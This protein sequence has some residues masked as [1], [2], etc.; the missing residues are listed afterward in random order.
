MLL[1]MFGQTL[2]AGWQFPEHPVGYIS[3]IILLICIFGM[4][5]TVNDFLY[6]NSGYTI[7]D[8]YVYC[9]KNP[10]V[11]ITPRGDDCNITMNK[12]YNENENWTRYII[13]E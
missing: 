13:E 11:L 3:S 5:F 9:G 4:F 7:Q 10:E 12:I 8:V 6:N 1:F 2:G